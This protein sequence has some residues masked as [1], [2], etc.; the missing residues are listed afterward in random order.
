[1]LTVPEEILKEK[2]KDLIEAKLGWGGS[3]AWSN[4]DFDTLSDKI[5]EVTGVTLS[6]TTLKRIWGKVKYDSAPT[7]TTLDTLARF[8]GFEHW[9]D[10]RQ[11]HTPHNPPA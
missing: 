5:F 9:R 8:L 7:V 4:R 6:Q 3:E 11:Q 10:F 2:C 1:M